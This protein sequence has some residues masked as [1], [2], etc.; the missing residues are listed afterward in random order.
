MKKI[1]E[2]DTRYLINDKLIYV[3]ESEYYQYSEPELESYTI[4][5]DEWENALL[6]IPTSKI[7]KEK[8]THREY[9]A[10]KRLLLEPVKRLYLD[11]IKNMR[12]EVQ[13]IRIETQNLSVKELKKKMK[14]EDFDLWLSEPEISFQKD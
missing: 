8:H 3:H 11:E 1:L 5:K 4:K 6:S 9:L 12:I 14:K 13:S 7:K 10:S 2:I